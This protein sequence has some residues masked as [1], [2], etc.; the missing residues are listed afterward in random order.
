MKQTFIL[1]LL[2]VS[3]FIFG[4]TK[5]DMVKPAVEAM[6]A[7]APVQAPTAAPVFNDVKLENTT[8]TKAVM[9]FEDGNYDTKCDYGTIDYNGEPLRVVKFKNVGTE[10]L[11]IKNARGSCGCTVPVWPKEPILP[12]ESSTIEI[13]YATNRVGKI[14]KKVTI[15]TNEEKEHVIDV[16]G[17]VLPEK[18]VESGVPTVEPS[19]IKGGN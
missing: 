1:C 8:P 17:D 18:K 19:L 5:G 7:V 3:G 10:P 16:I 6:P 2:L 4:Q 12:G 13:R 11:V 9:Q 15:T 14:N